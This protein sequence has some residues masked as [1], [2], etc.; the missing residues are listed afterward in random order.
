MGSYAEYENTVLQDLWA[1]ADQHHRGELDGCKRQGRPPVLEKWFALRGVL[2]PPDG[3][4]ENDIRAAI[5]QNQRHR[6]FCSLKSSQAL[7]Q[8]V[9]GAV[10]AFDRLDLLRD[11][12]AECGRPAFFKDHYD[13]SLIFEHEVDSLQEPRR[14]SI[15]VLLSGPRRRVAIECK[16]T[17]REFGTCSRPKLRPSDP[18]YSEQYCDGSYRIQFGRQERCTLTEIDIR[19]WHYLPHLFD[20][21]ADRDHMSC[22]FREV[23]QLGRN[24]LGAALAS[25]GELDPS[26]GHVLVIYDARNPEFQKDGTAERQW[27]LATAACLVPGFMRRLSW[28]RLMTVIAREPE[29]AYLVDSV[30]RKYGLQPE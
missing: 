24:A 9:F 2:V 27:A 18:N 25:D 30:G 4:K 13:W 8:S 6:W 1:W 20:W 17:E 15:D 21:P 11:V 3:S 23:Y 16:F 28:Q 7:T 10:R 22:P 26:G 5:P 19:Y 12:S 14:T 29:L